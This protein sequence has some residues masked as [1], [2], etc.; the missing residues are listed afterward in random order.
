MSEYQIE[1]FSQQ[2][3]SLQGSNK[4]VFSIE[5]Q[6]GSASISDSLD[7]HRATLETTLHNIFPEHKEETKLGRARQI[8]GDIISDATDDEVISSLAQFQHLLGSWFDDYE[9]NIF[10]GKTLNQILKGG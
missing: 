6:A 1:L 3:Q 7:Q 8:L 5:N 10:D 4:G 9:K 2:K